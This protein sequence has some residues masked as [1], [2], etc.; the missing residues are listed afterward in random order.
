MDE[1]PRPSEEMAELAAVVAQEE[2]IST[3]WRDF[4]AA[5]T[6]MRGLLL[7]A[8]F[9]LSLT[10]CAAQAGAPA[11][12]GERCSTIQNR[13]SAC[14]AIGAAIEATCLS[15]MC[16]TEEGALMTDLRQLSSSEAHFLIALDDLAGEAELLS[17]LMAVCAALERSSADACIQCDDRWPP[18]ATRTTARQAS[19]CP[20]H[21]PARQLGLRDGSCS[22]WASIGAGELNFSSD[23]DLIVLDPRC[24]PSLDPLGGRSP[25]CS[26]RLTRRLVRILQER[27]ADG[28][29]FRVD[30]RL[31]PD[32]GS[33]PLAI[34]VEAALGYYESVGQNWE[35]AAHDQGAPRAPATWPPAPAFLAELPPYHLAQVPRLRGHRRRPLDQA[36]DP[37]AQG[38]R[39]RS[40]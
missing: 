20:I 13:G 31:R 28:Y 24:R 39:R 12:L 25:T 4:L 2:G 38:P 22:A 33:T 17:A 26:S 14:R 21:K 7:A 8:V 29:V 37:C 35:R 11:V 36:P 5:K 6:P 18:F 1:V 32:P 16:V 40:P 19:G 27:T 15:P 34:P 3:G 30:L 10:S 23:I 9:D